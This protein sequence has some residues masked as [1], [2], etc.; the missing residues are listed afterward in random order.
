MSDP[1]RCGVDLVDVARFERMLARAGDLDELFTKAELEE[2]RAKRHPAPSL[3]G[4]FAAKEACLKLFPRETA[5]KD[6]DFRDIEIETDG[7]GAPRVRKSPA[8]AKILKRNRFAHVAISI[9]HTATHA[10]AVAVAWRG[11]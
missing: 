8:F 9:S 2:C 7:Y 11:R 4:R 1:V 10:C 6:L 3:A 5:L